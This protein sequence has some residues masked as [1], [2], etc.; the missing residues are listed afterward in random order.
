MHRS[1]SLLSLSSVVV[2]N[3]AAEL[4]VAAQRV[5]NLFESLA[6]FGYSPA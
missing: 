3:S 1:T 2:E 6:S 4:T 5:L